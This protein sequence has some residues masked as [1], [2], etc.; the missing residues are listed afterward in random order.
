MT[1][2]AALQLFEDFD[3]SLFSDPW[4]LDG[5]AVIN[6][7]VDGVNA[8]TILGEHIGKSMKRARRRHLDGVRAGRLGYARARRV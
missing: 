8:K 7:F 1:P 5:D 4:L 6:A 2:D 3:K